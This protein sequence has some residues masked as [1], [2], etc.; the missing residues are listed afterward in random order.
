MILVIAIYLAVSLTVTGNL[1]NEEI[2][3]AKDYDLPS[4]ALQPRPTRIAGTVVRKRKLL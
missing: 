1:S 3:R 4:E 2:E